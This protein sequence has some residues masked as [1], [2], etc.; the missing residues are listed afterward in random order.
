MSESPPDLKPRFPIRRFDVFAEYNRAK[1]VSDGLP[2]PIAKG[3]ALWVAKVVAGRRSGSVPKAEVRGE[4]GREERAP[5]EREE[6]GF[7]SIGGVPQTDTMFD[8]E[9]V[10]RM[11][12]EFYRQVFQPA[13]DAAYR[14][15]QQYT[16]IR[17]T[18]RKTWK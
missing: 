15:G 2:E 17:D 18:I 4:R 14:A 7:R 3:R 10:D 1:N 13:I 9:I 12:R 6:E 16:D 5:E 8:K 11:G